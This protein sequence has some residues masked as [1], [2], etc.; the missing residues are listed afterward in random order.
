VEKRAAAM[1][2]LHTTEDVA[3]IGLLR[4]KQDPVR[5]LSRQLSFQDIYV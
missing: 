3:S 1:K 4:S 5:L 2:P